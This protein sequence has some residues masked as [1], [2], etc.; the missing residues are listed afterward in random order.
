MLLISF[1]GVLLDYILYY[2][3]KNYFLKMIKIY[4]ATV[5]IML[6]IF[7]GKPPAPRFITL[8]ETGN[9]ICISSCSHSFPL[10]KMHNSNLS[11]ICY[12]A[13]LQASL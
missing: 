4:M 9:P 5:G 10:A 11:Q 3:F 7:Y 8:D 1:F 13:C 12:F 2:L 6:A